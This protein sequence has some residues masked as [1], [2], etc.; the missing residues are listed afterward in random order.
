MAQH[1]EEYKD[2]YKSFFYSDQGIVRLCNDFCIPPPDY[3]GAGQECVEKDYNGGVSD[4]TGE[5]YE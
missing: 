3:L 2:G 5:F 1:T 4:K